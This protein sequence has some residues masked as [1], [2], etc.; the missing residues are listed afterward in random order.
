[1]V[2]F[3]KQLKVSFYTTNKTNII[4]AFDFGFGFGDIQQIFFILLNKYT[5]QRSFFY[6]SDN[7]EQ[8]QIILFSKFNIKSC[9]L[10]LGLNSL[11]LA[12]FEVNEIFSTTESDI[13]L[14]F[15]NFL[16][17]HEIN[18]F[19]NDN[20]PFHQTWINNFNCILFVPTNYFIDHGQKSQFSTWVRDWRN[21]LFII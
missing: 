6:F 16:K 15:N 9:F 14:M 13:H 20:C 19:I 18:I 8:F 17:M 10:F 1:M 4:L 5:L 21:I 11:F 12:R 7:R 2:F 3:H